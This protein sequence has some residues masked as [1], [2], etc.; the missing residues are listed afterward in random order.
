MDE[1][2]QRT[3]AQNNAIHLWLEQ[4]A[5]VL[6]ENG[7]DMKTVLKY[8]VDIVPTKENLK[9]VVWRPI[10][11]SLY[12]KRSTASL[13]TDEVSDVYEI[14]HKHFAQHHQVELPPFPSIEK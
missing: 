13:K 2:P 10:Q 6:R 11:A 9:E 7:V 1:K 14:I 12:G 4:V 3:E 5:K 8:S